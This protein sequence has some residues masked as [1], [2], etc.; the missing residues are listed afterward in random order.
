MPPTENRQEAKVTSESTYRYR[1][2]SGGIR[3]CHMLK[4]ICFCYHSSSALQFSLLMTNWMMIA[5]LSSSSKSWNNARRLPSL[6]SQIHVSSKCVRFSLIYNYVNFLLA[7]LIALITRK[8]SI[9]RITPKVQVIKELPLLSET[10]M[11]K[12]EVQRCYLEEDQLVCFFLSF[13]LC[14]RF[15]FMI[16]AAPAETEINGTKES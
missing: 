6:L 8:F 13:Y 4:L 7:F 16:L 3:D 2:H 12:R 15:E 1:R 10:P 11:L 14:P 5:L 9:T